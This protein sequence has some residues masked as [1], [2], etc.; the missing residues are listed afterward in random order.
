MNHLSADNHE[1]TVANQDRAFQM[2]TMLFGLLLGLGGMHLLV[3]RPMTQQLQTMQN[4]VGRVESRLDALTESRDRAG[5]VASLMSNLNAQFDQL[6]AARET[7]VGIR[8]FCDAVTEETQRAKNSIASLERIKTVQDSV[9]EQ[10]RTAATA[11]KSLAGMVEVQ[12]AIVAEADQTTLAAAAVRKLAGIKT[13]VTENTR[14]LAEAGKNLEELIQ[15]KNAISAQ[16]ETNASAQQ[17]ADALIALKTT[18]TDDAA[19]NET[20]AAS[21]AKLVEIQSKLNAQTADAADAI[22]MLELLSD[23]QDDFQTHFSQ[24]ESVQLKLIEFSLLGSRVDR[25]AEMLR[26]LT[27][28]V[29]LR[30]LNPNDLREV[31]DMIRGEHRPALAQKP[32]SARNVDPTSSQAIKIVSPRRITDE[33]KTA[34]SDESTFE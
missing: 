17:S 3:V 33:E 20:A 21:L 9:I 24:L 8:E 1:P 18:L 6:A 30:R 34:R 28:L 11:S 27:E 25:V 26:P 2:T 14:D 16:A 32:D 5:Q 23:L 4:E 13:T 29:T 7:L 22:Q 31:A 10:G 15:L 19:D 12:D